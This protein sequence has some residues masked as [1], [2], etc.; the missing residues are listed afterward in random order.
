MIKNERKLDV[1]TE[2]LRPGSQGL[3]ED[4]NDGMNNAGPKEKMSSKRH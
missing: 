1:A 3:A 4:D 2:G